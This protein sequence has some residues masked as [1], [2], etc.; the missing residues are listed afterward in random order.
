LSAGIFEEV[1]RFIGIKFF[2][3]RGL[4][5]E[6]GVVFG[7]GHGGIEA[8]LLVGLNYSKVI[9]NVITGQA[10][11]SIVNVPSYLFLF[12]GIE[13]ILAIT[14]HIGMTMLV[15]Y[16]IKYKKR[17]YLFYAIL[18]HT[19]IDS[20]LLILKQVGLDLNVWITTGYIAV[21][22]ILAL[23]IT[24]KFKATLNKEKIE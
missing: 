8:F 12:G 20:P 6:N 24:V 21:F 18:F 4:N 17:R 5:W 10:I 7:L 22:A 13:R 1:G 9:L 14:L 23:I 19:L 15:L 3:K 16:S 2:L 11:K